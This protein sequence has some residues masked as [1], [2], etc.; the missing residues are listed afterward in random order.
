M[1]WWAS[2]G[3]LF[4]SVKELVGIPQVTAGANVFLSAQSLEVRASIKR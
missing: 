3:S 2:S 1:S 4:E